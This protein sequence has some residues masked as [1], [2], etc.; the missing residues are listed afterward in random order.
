MSKRTTTE[1]Y[2]AKCKMVHNNT[3]DYT[4]LIYIDNTCKVTIRCKIHGNFLQRPSDHR[5]GFGCPSCS[6]KVRGN[7]EQFIYKAKNVHGDFYDYSKVEYVSLSKEIVIIC[8][9][10]G[11]FKIKPR[12]HIYG[13]KN[14]CSLCCRSKGE[15]IIEKW[16]LNNNIH[17][18]EQK[19]FNNLKSKRFDFYLPLYNTCIE[20][21][22]A[23]HFFEKNQKTKNKDLAKILFNEVKRR[24]EEK[25]LF[26]SENKIRLIRIPFTE[27]RN[28]DNILNHEILRHTTKQAS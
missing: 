5:R 11:D 2:I 12:F 18:E 19:K 20:Y 27:L 24:D 8:P 26:C 25:T 4:N 21:D 16:L 10:H 17:F 7:T 3:Y 6:G 9:K 23:Q 13:S 1:E 22:G 15:Q 28:I 14:G